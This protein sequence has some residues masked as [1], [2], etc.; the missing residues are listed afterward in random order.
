MVNRRPASVE[1]RDVKVSQPEKANV[2]VINHVNEGARILYAYLL[3][4][5]ALFEWLGFYF[6]FC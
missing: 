6:I 2:R 1:E 3:S 5:K 4:C